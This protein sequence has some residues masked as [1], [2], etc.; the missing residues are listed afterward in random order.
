MPTQEPT[1]L[2]E[3]RSGLKVRTLARR[4]WIWLELVRKGDHW[5][6]LTRFDRR[7]IRAPGSKPRGKTFTF[8]MCAIL[9]AA[10]YGL[11]FQTGNTQRGRLDFGAGAGEYLFSVFHAL[12]DDHKAVNNRVISVLFF[13]SFIAI[14]E[15]DGRGRGCFIE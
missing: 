4:G 1:T 13:L 10:N 6:P 7:L 9:P 5:R 14:N 12:G 2:R 11:P 3:Y 8:L 15:N